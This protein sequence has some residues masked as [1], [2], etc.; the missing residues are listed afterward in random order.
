MYYVDFYSLFNNP[1]K[2][3]EY[4]LAEASEM[5]PELTLFDRGGLVFGSVHIPLLKIKGLVILFPHF[6]FLS[7]SNNKLYNN[8]AK[9]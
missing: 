2:D 6:Q 1:E 3:W 8:Y 4:V 5:P 9:R 7:D